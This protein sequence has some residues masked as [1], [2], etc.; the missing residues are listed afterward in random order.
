MNC[1]IRAV[2]AP[3]LQ[4]VSFYLTSADNQARMKEIVMEP[5][6][7]GTAGTPSFFMNYTTA[8]VLMDDLWASGVRPTEGHGSA[9]AIRAVERHLEDMRTLVFREAKQ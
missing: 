8:Q 4:G 5:Q 9:G 3:W 2:A 7:P 6:D 1:S